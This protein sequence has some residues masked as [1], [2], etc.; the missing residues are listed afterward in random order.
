MVRYDGVPQ[1]LAVDRVRA[2]STPTTGLVIGEPDVAATWFP[3]NDHPTD[4]AS[5]TFKITVPQGSRRSLTACWSGSR[6]AAGWTTWT[7]Q[8]EEPMASY[9]ATARSA[10]S[11]CTPTG[12]SASGSG[13]RS[14]PTCST[15]SPQPRTGDSSPCS[16]VAD[17]AYKRLTRTISVP[18]GG[19]ELSLLDRPATPSRTGTS[20]SSRR[21]RSAGRLDH[22]ARPQRAHRASDTG[23]SCPSGRPAPVPHPLPDATTATAPASPSGTTGDWWAA[24]GASGGY[25]QWAVDLS[26][27]AGSDVEV[28][29]TYASDDVVQGAGVVR[30]RRRRLDRRGHHLV[31]GRRRHAGRLD[32]ARRARRQRAATPNDWIAGTVGRRAAPTAVRSPRARS[33]A[34]RRSSTSWRTTS[35]GTRSR[36]RRDRRRLWTPSAS[37]WRTRPGRST[38]RGFFSDP[39]RRR[40]RRARARPPVVRRQP[41]RRRGGST[42]GST[43]ASRPTRSGCGASDEGLGTAQEIF[44]FFYGIFRRRRPV[45]GADDRRSRARTHLFDFPVYARGAMTLHQL[46]LAVGDEDFFRILRRVG[47]HPAR[48]QRHHR[49]VHRASPSGS[50]ASSWTRCSRP[51]CSPRGARTCPA[52]RHCL[53][54]RRGPSPGPCASSRRRP[55]AC[56]P[57]STSR[58]DTGP[59]HGAPAGGCRDTGPRLGLVRCAERIHARLRDLAGRSVAAV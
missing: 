30:R 10:S 58:T 40:R 2:S 23:F 17:A 22:A 1:T 32:R 28:S 55:A 52:R 15:R 42:S 19:A 49:R 27:Y 50:P 6:D 56:S 18:A 33:P 47:Q 3:V 24:T 48:R 54:H 4:K 5:Y 45:L 13:T 44:D 37:R 31:R 8:R 29:I 57:G 39:V 7:W 14:T 41:R 43:R 25:E 21:T 51:G 12:R 38:R 53:D 46:R 59:M 9:L 20:S 26:A 16:Q 35:A 11:T 36:R 34:S